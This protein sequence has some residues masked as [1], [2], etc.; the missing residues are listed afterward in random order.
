MWSVDP[1]LGAVSVG[2]KLR[3]LLVVVET[4]S[5]VVARREVKISSERRR[6]AIAVLVWESY[7][8]SPVSW[9]LNSNTIK[10]IR[11]DWIQRVG[12]VRSWASPLNWLRDTIRQ[13]GD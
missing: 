13:I 4:C 2:R 6:I 1:A 9:I 3:I 5:W 8:C 12:G 10:S 7:T 11:V